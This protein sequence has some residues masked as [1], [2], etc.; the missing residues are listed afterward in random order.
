MKSLKVHVLSKL[1]NR[2]MLVKV[3]HRRV[4]L[5]SVDDLCNDLLMIC[6]MM[7][8]VMMMIIILMVMMMLKLIRRN[9]NLLITL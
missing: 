9:Y 1:L 2:D 5:G 3:L 4:L 8:M 7:M 6:V